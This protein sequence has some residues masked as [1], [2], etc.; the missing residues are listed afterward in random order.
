MR[1]MLPLTETMNISIVVIE[2]TTH[3]YSIFFITFVAGSSRIWVPSTYCST[4]CINLLKDCPG[5]IRHFKR[6]VTLPVLAGF[7][8]H[9]A[10]ENLYSQKYF[11][12]FPEGYLENLFTVK[13]HNF[14][15]E[16]FPDYRNYPK[17]MISIIIPTYNED[18]NIRRCLSALS[19]QTI[20]REFMTYRRRRGLKR[21]YTGNRGGICRSC[22]HPGFRAGTWCTER[23]FHPG[24]T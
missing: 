4:N 20:P 23:R 13:I 2:S 19:N 9:Y 24:T 16:L 18:P 1:V 12:R 15:K 7:Y 22:L 11:R 21:P 10:P 3:W 8:F 5:Y 6:S 14:G 17:I